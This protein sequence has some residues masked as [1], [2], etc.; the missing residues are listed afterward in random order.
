RNV[1]LISPPDFALKQGLDR[2]ITRWLDRLQWGTSASK[3]WSIECLKRET[4][5]SFV[6]EV[7][8]RINR[9]KSFAHTKAKL[10]VDLLA[11]LGD[12]AGLPVLIECTD[13]ANVMVRHAAL[14]GVSR[15]EGDEALACLMKHTDS[16]HEGTRRL[17]LDLLQVRDEEKVL[18]FFQEALASGDEEVL[19]YAMKALALTEKTQYAADIRPYLDHEDFMLRTTATQALL[20]LKDAAA[21]E[22]LSQDLLY[23]GPVIKKAAINNLFYAKALPP[24][25]VLEKLARDDDVEVRAHFVAVVVSLLENFKGEARQPL[26]EILD[27]MSEDPRPE[28]RSKAVE[29]L[30]RTGRADVALPFLR[31]LQSDYGSALQEAVL[32]TT[33]SLT[34]T[35][36]AAPLLIERFRNDPDLTPVDRLTLLNGLSQLGSPDGLDLYFEVIL[37]GWEARTLVIAPFSL[38]GHAAFKVHD[39]GGDVLDRWL[40]ALEQDD[41]DHMLYLFINSARNLEDGRAADKLLEVASQEGRP[42]WLRTEAIVSCSFLNDIGIGPRLLEFANIERNPSLAAKAHKVFWNFF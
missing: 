19:S 28:I 2:R 21:L 27:L 23:K 10:Y 39:L 14:K 29:G 35:R 24:L 42:L 12:P 30:Y 6:P 1:Q 31:R 17:C 5:R 25:E 15:F 16:F 7:I 13:D 33:E 8:R 18:A 22:R 34:L 9:L 20:R 36:E 37:G 26:Q 3:N 38:D 40:A 4:D 32:F 41:S 11:E